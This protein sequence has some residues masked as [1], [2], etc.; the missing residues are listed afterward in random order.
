MKCCFLTEHADD[1]D[2]H[3]GET[4]CLLEKIDTEWYRGK[5]GNRTGIFPASFVKVV[6]CRLFIPCY[7]RPYCVGFL[8][9]LPA[10][11]TY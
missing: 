9:S 2:L 11:K 3:S 1:L 4:V 5:C 6:V 8:V 7:I 10:Q